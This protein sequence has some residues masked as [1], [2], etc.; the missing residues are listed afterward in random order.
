MNKII[1]SEGKLFQ[2]IIDKVIFGKE[3]YLG[4]DYSTGVKREDLAEYYEEVDEL[5]EIN[6]LEE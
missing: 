2:R 1:A 4:F 5:I 3:I 6:I